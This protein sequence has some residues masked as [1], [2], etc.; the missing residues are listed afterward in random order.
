[1]ETVSIVPPEVHIRVLVGQRGSYGDS[2]YRSS[3]SAY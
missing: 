3:R 2:K 1:M